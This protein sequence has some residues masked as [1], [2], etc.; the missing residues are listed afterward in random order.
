MSE[1]ISG[2]V[3]A[4]EN[5]MNKLS[6]TILFHAIQSSVFKQMSKVNY[7]TYVITIA[8]INIYHS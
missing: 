8:F 7:V 5:P 6:H 2:Q 3:L 1:I 4:S